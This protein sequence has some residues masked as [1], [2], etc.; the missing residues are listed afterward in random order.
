M[1]PI[2]LWAFGI[3]ESVLY[4]A[5][6]AGQ[7]L[8][9][10]KRL[11]YAIRSTSNPIPTRRAYI[12]RNWDLL[13]LRLV[14]G[15]VVFVLWE[16]MDLTGMIASH[17]NVVVPPLLA[18]SPFAGLMLGYSSDSM[19]DWALSSKR[20]PEWIRRVIP[21]IPLNGDG[22]PPKIDPDTPRG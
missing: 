18:Q 6:F 15:W 7:C 19:V 16:H 20:M 1:K 2:D 21:V 5:F 22:G 4:L 3:N 8:Y 12:T 10:L 11:S 17:W 14:L 9:V 13:F